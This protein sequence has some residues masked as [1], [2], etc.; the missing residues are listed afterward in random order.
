[1]F[2][3]CNVVD[4]PYL[5]SIPLDPKL[6]QCCDQGISLYTE[7]PDSL[8]TKA[9]IRIVQKLKESVSHAD[10]EDMDV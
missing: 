5:G 4:V 7:Y 8:V 3:C 1:L 10:T 9:Y 6:A 2:V